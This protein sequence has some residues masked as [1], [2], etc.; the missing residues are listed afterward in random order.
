MASEEVYWGRNTSEAIETLVASS[1]TSRAVSISQNSLHLIEPARPETDPSLIF[2][3]KAVI[4]HRD[5]YFEFLTFND[6]LNQPKLHAVCLVGKLNFNRFFQRQK[7]IIAL[8][9]YVKK[10][11]LGFF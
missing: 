8:P 6:R 4:I 5:Q 10:R 9:V 11:F 3:Q 7:W 2:G 1:T